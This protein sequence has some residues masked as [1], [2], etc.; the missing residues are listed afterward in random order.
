MPEIHLSSTVTDPT[1]YG[2][3]VL[4]NYGSTYWRALLGNGAWGL[5]E[6]LRSFCHT[7]GE[8]ASQFTV[9]VSITLLQEI[10]GV[11]DRTVL[12]GRVK[13]ANRKTYT[14]PGWIE[15][16]QTHGLLTAREIVVKKQ[17]QYAFDVLLHPP[18]LTQ[19]QVAQLPTRLQKK[20]T[21]LLERCQQAS[22]KREGQI[23]K[24]RN[25]GVLF[26]GGKHR[27][28]PVGNS[29]E[30][31]L[32]IPISPIGNSKTNNN[33][34]TK[35]EKQQHKSVVVEKLISFGVEPKKA[36]VLA[37]KHPPNQIKKQL[38]HLAF[39]SQKSQIDNPAAWLI[40]AIER[41]YEVPEQIKNYQQKQQNKQDLQAELRDFQQKQNRQQVEVENERQKILQAKRKD[42]TF[43]EGDEQQWQKVIETLQQQ[44]ISEAW[45]ACMT[46]LGQDENNLVLGVWGKYAY[47]QVSALKKDIQSEIGEVFSTDKKILLES[48]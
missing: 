19:E 33:Q 48:L 41:G 16:L 40:R 27:N 43:S 25:E 29:K 11:K 13:K 17:M 2:Y 18:Q 20:H 8:D 47:Q 9:R 35:P 36:K 6:V 37:Q 3:Q 42:L 1:R 7:G 44:D 12:I 15:V 14:Y 26:R 46:Y 5:Y 24:L 38:E 28:E 32:E 10:L 39:I 30:Q 22:E 45:L 21:Q 23:R 31:D 4:Y 34:E